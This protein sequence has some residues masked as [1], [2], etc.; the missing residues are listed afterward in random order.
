MTDRATGVFITGN[1]RSTSKPRKSLMTEVTET[2]MPKRG[3]VGEKSG[4]ARRRR[5]KVQRVKRPGAIA[6]DDLVPGGEVLHREAKRVKLDRNGVIS[7]ELA[8]RN[9][10]LNQFRS[11]KNIVKV[12]GTETS[13]ACGDNR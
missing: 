6:P 10:I 7:S 4:E 8:H 5:R 1:S 12:K 2:L 3:G 11:D 9:K 13:R